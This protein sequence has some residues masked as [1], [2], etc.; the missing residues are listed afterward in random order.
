MKRYKIIR[1]ILQENKLERGE[2]CLVKAVK[3]V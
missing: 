2:V 3:E 1:I